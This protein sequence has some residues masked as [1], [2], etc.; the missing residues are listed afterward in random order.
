MDLGTFQ[1]ID[2]KEG[3]R[4]LSSQSVALLITS[5]PYYGCRDYDAGSKGETARIRGFHC[6]SDELGHEKTPYDYVRRLGDIFGDGSY[7]NRTSMMRKTSPLPV[8][9]GG[10]LIV[11][12]GDVIARRDYIDPMGIYPPIR[13]MEFM[14]VHHMFVAEMRRRG[15]MTY[16]QSPM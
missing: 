16:G 12:I 15:W 7:L 3:V 4:R 8:E 9:V 11:N 14:G 2:A 13:K 6:E 5:P 1:K 10:S